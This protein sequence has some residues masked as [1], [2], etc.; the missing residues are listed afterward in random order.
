MW[1]SLAITIVIFIGTM[2]WFSSIYT[3]REDELLR[4]EKKD[5]KRE[6]ISKNERNNQ[7]YFVD[8][9]GYYGVYVVNI[10]T[11]HGKLLYIWGF[12]SSLF[13]SRGPFASYLKYSKDFRVNT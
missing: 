13:I 4:L 7:K 10:L 5:G 11:N 3:K 2:V 9:V 8:N 1:L 12:R 6:N